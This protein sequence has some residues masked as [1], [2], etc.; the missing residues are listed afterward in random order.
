MFAILPINFNVN[1]CKTLQ[2][3]SAWT[4]FQNLI[5]TFSTNLWRVY[6]KVLFID[7]VLIENLQPLKVLIE[8]SDLFI[9]TK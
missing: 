7:L 9:Y 6:L 5:R 4:A 8:F 1:V 2:T 3:I